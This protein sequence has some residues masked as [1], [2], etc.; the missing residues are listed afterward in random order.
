MTR[1]LFFNFCLVHQGF[2]DPTEHL[3]TA[4]HLDKTE[5]CAGFHVTFQAATCPD[6]DVRDAR[7]V[8]PFQLGS[9]PRA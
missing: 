9:R 7:R 4:R 1:K 2:F 8:A 3:P 6:L 5:M